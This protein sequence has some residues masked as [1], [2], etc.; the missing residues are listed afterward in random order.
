MKCNR[1]V[2]FNYFTRWDWLF[3]LF[4][5]RFYHLTCLKLN[6]ESFSLW[7]FFTSSFVFAQL[8]F[9][10]RLSS[11]SLRNHYLTLLFFI[12]DHDAIIM[13]WSSTRKRKLLKR[14]TSI[15]LCC[16]ACA[17]LNRKKSEN[18]ENSESR[19]RISS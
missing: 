6:V 3:S 12:D 15:K 1:F 2:L 19:D 8:F 10:Y 5:F 16:V 18:R 13:K 7:F 4:R 17:S 11:R 9:I 14:K